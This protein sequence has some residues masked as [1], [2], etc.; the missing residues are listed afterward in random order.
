MEERK[1]DFLSV[2]AG[3][4]GLAAALYTS[5][6]GLK[7][8]VIDR[9][10][11]GGQMFMTELV[12]N[13]PGFVEGIKGTELSELMQKQAERFGAEVAYGEV[14][15]VGARGADG[16]V[17][18][19]TESGTIRAKTVMIATGAHP[20]KLGIPG[21]EEF[22]GRGVSYCAICDGPFFRDQAVAVVGGGDSAVEEAHYLSKICSKVYIVHRRDELRAKKV[23]QD[24]AF[25]TENI[26]IVWSHVPVEVAGGE[27]GV[28]G[29]V[30]KSVG[31]DE[32]RTLACGGVFFYVGFAPNTDFIDPNIIKLNE[33]GFIITNENLET[34][35]PGVYAAGDVRRMHN[36]QITTAVADGTEVALNVD[37][38][39][40]EHG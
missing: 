37:R 5:R 23:A 31:T 3:P 12:E 10:S 2:G 8:L 16:L 18:V 30:V 35:V 36:R 15:S 21:E 33:Q 20:K 4:A 11:P 24:A 19:E 27:G 17:A 40:Q 25:R 34:S 22:A 6:A 32:A 38:Y 28:E 26:E 13:Y 9:G 1:V 14:R 29:L 39:L 7:T